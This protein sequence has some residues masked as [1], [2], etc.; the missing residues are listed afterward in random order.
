M[1]T[2][3]NPLPSKRPVI[4]SIYAILLTFIA[5]FVVVL[6]GSALLG[7]IMRVSNQ[8][9]RDTPDVVLSAI[10]IF[11]AA[12]M[13]FGAGIGLLRMRRWGLV[14]ALIV[15]FGFVIYQTFTTLVVCQCVPFI[16]QNYTV[17]GLGFFLLPYVIGL[18][19]A[20]WHWN[21]RHLFK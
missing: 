18:P 11:I 13:T 8:D 19:I 20:G 10:A 15:T 12:I 7:I 4:V 14:L 5:F 2:S 6:D 17:R 3:K 1:T 21:K 16:Q 9:Y